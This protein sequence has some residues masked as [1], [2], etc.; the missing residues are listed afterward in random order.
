MRRKTKTRRKKRKKPTRTKTK[1]TS[2][3]TMRKRTRNSSQ[4]LTHRIRTLWHPN[5]VRSLFQMDFENYNVRPSI[6]R[7][8]IALSFFLGFATLLFAQEPIEPPTPHAPS[9]AE[10]TSKQNSPHSA[11][12]LPNH[13]FVRGTL[14]TPQGLALPGPEL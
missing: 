4:I 7:S 13:F 2:R 11:A 10:S 12:K 3:K 14:F 9:S 6:V 5:S 8:N 1:K